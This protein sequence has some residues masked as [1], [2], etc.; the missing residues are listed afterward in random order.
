VLEGMKIMDIEP[1]YSKE[2]YKARASL[3]AILRCMEGKK[4]KTN[5]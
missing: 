5:R 3:M 2:W 4:R 1:L